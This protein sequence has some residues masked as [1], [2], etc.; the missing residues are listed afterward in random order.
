[1]AK[2]I[3]GHVIDLSLS[4]LDNREKDRNSINNLAGEGLADDLSLFINNLKNTSIIKK[5][6]YVVIDIDINGIIE[7]FIQITDPFIIP[8]S[9]RTIVK[10]GTIDCVVYNSNTTNQFQVKNKSNNQAI[11]PGLV[12]II[13]Y[14]SVKTI[15]FD[16]IDPTRFPSTVGINNSEFNS[17]EQGISDI[18]DINIPNYID[19]IETSIDNYLYLKSNSILTYKDNNFNKKI[20]L[21]DSVVIRNLDINGNPITV[22]NSLEPTDPGIFIVDGTNRFRA[23]SDNSNPW[24]TNTTNFTS[25]ISEKVTVSELEITNPIISGLSTNNVAGT[26]SNTIIIDPITNMAITNIYY[27]TVYINGE[28]FNLVTVKE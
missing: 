24:N 14:D 10:C 18:Y 4:E 3:Q 28:L 6:Q 27:F 26:I 25:T 22:Q 8:F 15:N 20:T 12:D 2:G 16:N 19:S 11:N 21:S 9:N 17:L 7:P 23:F 1:M 13:R 5:T